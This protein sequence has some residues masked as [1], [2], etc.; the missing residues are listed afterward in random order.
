[1]V[2]R[3]L[4]NVKPYKA[5]KHFEMTAFRLHG[6]EES[7]AKKFWMGLSHFL[8]GGGAEYDESA[9]EKVYYVLKGQITV[10]DKNNNKI[11]LNESD[12]IHIDPNEGR[13]IINESNMPASTLV[14]ITYPEA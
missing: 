3:E 11:V 6:K 4:K 2:K 1:M 8:P 14:V 13:A 9:T 7:G 12:S 5:P 10:V